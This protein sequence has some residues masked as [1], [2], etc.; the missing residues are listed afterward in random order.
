MKLKHYILSTL[1]LLLFNGIVYIMSEFNLANSQKSIKETKIHILSTHYQV[2]LETQTKI[3]DTAYHLTISN[4]KIMKILE[5]APDASPQRQDELR[6]QLHQLLSL[7][8][9]IFQKEGILQYH[10]IF[11][12]NRVFYRAHKPSKFGDDLTSERKDFAYTN[13]E[14]KVFRGFAQGKTAHGFRNIYPL[15]DT[16]KKHIG[17]M[18]VSFSSDSFQWYLDHVSGIHSHFLVNK[19]IFD[20]TAWERNDLVL[21]YMQSAENAEYMLTLTDKHTK[22]VCVA[23]NKMRLAPYKKEIDSKMSKG[24]PFGVTVTPYSDTEE[25]EIVSFIPIKNILEDTT[26]AWIVTY[27]KSPILATVTQNTA[28]VRGVMFIISLTIL[29][30]ILRQV[31]SNKELQ[32]LLVK[33]KENNETKEQQQK[34]L[35]EQAKHAQ[36]GEMIGNIAHQWRQPL[37]VISTASTGILVEKEF[38]VLTDEKFVKSCEM[39]NQNAQYLSKT[40]DDFRNYIKGERVKVHFDLS[41]TIESFL[42][43]IQGSIKNHDI[44]VVVQLEDGIKIDGYPNELTQCLINIFNNAKDILK[45]KREENRAIIIATMSQDKNAIIT[46]KDN[47]GGIPQEVLPQIFDPYFTTKHKSQGTGLGLSMTRKLIVEGMDGDVVALNQEFEHD[48]MRYIGAEFRIALPI[49]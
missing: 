34:Q 47:A 32:L 4:D 31:K 14:K 48:G 6:K 29:Y 24:E 43:L 19:K 10:F 13:R 22:K 9:P 23:Q 36:M 37:S 25:T 8:Y 30:F 33:E 42:H 15:F 40:I 39:I 17:A 20:T 46:I 44:E 27:D 2:L 7:T 45:E 38:G 35:F 1:F 49:G 11:P 5:V 21:S 12:D 3:S 26:L 28:I 18:E 16:N 41:E